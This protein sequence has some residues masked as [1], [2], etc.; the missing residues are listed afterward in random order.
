[1]KFIFWFILLLASIGLAA[2]SVPCD[3]FFTTLLYDNVFYLKN[4][5]FVNAV[6]TG[7]EYFIAALFLAVCGIWSGHKIRPASFTLLPSNF[8]T[9]KKILFLGMSFFGWCI[10]FP[11]AFKM[12]FHRARPY[13]TYLFGG[14]CPFSSA[15]EKSFSCPIGDSFISGHTSFA[16]WLLAL[17]LIMPERIRKPAVIFSL[18][19]VLIVGTSRILGG[20]HFFTDV[21]FAA[22]LVGSGIFITWKK[23][24]TSKVSI[25]MPSTIC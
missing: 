17:A 11:Y 24:F 12:F 16:M 23:L 14:E 4:N 21:Y 13:Q 19:V 8:I 2:Y 18:S 6:D 9:T 1:M 3:L 15:F 22:L 20:Y 25:N 5:I 10:A 7:C